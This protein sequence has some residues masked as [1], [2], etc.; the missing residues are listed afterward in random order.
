[1]SKI[2]KYPYPET[3]YTRRLRV[4]QNETGVEQPEELGLRSDEY[5]T[6]ENSS[7]HQFQAD[8]YYLYVSLHLN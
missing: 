1:M 7:C 4:E 5:A 3:A 6:D 8:K 2:W